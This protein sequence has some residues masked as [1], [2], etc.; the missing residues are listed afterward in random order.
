MYPLHERTQDFSGPEKPLS[1]LA[2]QKPRL[3]KNSFWFK[4]PQISLELCVSGTVF[5]RML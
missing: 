3:K 1:I 2:L 4:V 5:F